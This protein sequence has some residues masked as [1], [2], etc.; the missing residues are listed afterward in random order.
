MKLKTVMLNKDYHI[1]FTLDDNRQ[2][3]FNFKNSLDYPAYNKLNDTTIFL[4]ACFDKDIIFWDLDCD[5][6]I[7]QLLSNSIAY[8]NTKNDHWIP[9]TQ[10]SFYEYTLNN[11]SF[12][13]K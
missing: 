7:D 5:I 6:H 10:K 13:S 12:E 4:S 1:L 2:F 3:I 11:W 9:A 8:T